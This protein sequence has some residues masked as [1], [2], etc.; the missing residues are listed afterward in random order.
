VEQLK[1]LKRPAEK[2]ETVAAG[3]E[4]AKFPDLTVDQAVVE[5]VKSAN[6]LFEHRLT[7]GGVAHEVAD[8]KKRLGLV[9]LS[10]AVD[11][12]EKFGASI[13]EK[14]NVSEIVTELLKSL[15]D[16]KNRSITSATRN[17]GWSD[18]ARV[19]PA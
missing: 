16:D 3:T 6:L 7:L 2:A 13:T 17:C 11:F 9:P 19:F 5:Y 10:T 1:G 15:R 4:Q 12:Y 8:L 18:S 14:K